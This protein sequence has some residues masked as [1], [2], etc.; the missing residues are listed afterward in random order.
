[1]RLEW[2]LMDIAKQSEEIIPVA[3]RPAL[4]T[5]LKEVSYA[6]ILMIVIIYIGGGYALHNLSEG[7]AGLF[8]EKVNMIS[9]LAVGIY[10]TVRF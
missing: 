7:L 9:H 1:M 10:H 6:P 4:E 2:V 3:N 8:D 5:L